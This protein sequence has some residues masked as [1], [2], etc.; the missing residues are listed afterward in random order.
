Q[1][2]T[3]G[4]STTPAGFSIGDTETPAAALAVQATSSDQNLLPDANITLGGSGA[5]RTISLTPNPNVSGTC[6]VTVTVS[7]GL[8]STPTIFNVNITQ[9]ST[10]YIAILTPEHGH[11]SSGTGSATLQVDA[12]GTQAVLRF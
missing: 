8:A 12:A 11:A 7:D 5:S 1:A 10:L 9:A 4:Q 2:A 6:Q 3:A